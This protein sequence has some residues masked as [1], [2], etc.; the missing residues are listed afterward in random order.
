MRRNIGNELIVALFAAVSLIFAAVFAVLLST[1][2]S[3]RPTPTSLPTAQEIDMPVLAVASRTPERTDLPP[4]DTE[5]LPTVRTAV[6]TLTSAIILAATES[7]ALTDV[8]GISPTSV[9]TVAQATSGVIASATGQVPVVLT[10]TAS[11]SG[12]T[13]VLA[14]PEVEATERFPDFDPTTLVPTEVPAESGTAL[15]QARDA[16]APVPHPGTLPASPG[17]A[18]VVTAVSTSLAEDLTASPT[19]RDGLTEVVTATPTS[20]ATTEVTETIPADKEST[21]TTASA[22]PASTSA[23]MDGTAEVATEAKETS[24]LAPVA[25][26]IAEVSVTASATSSERVSEANTEAP[27]AISTVAV[28]TE[29]I[30]AELEKNTVTARAELRSTAKPAAQTEEAAV[31]S[32]KATPVDGILVDR[33][34]RTIRRLDSIELMPMR[35]PVVAPAATTA[36]A[37]VSLTP[38]ATATDLGVETETIEAPLT[39]TARMG[40]TRAD[41]PT[42]QP[43][44]PVFPPQ[45]TE[46]DVDASPAVET[47]V[48]GTLAATPSLSATGA[49]GRAAM[50]SPT[51]A[52]FKETAATKLPAVEEKDRRTPSATM[53]TT[54][55]GIRDKPTHSA[56][57]TPSST[58]V[59]SDALTAT[60]TKIVIVAQPVENQTDT[61]RATAEPATEESDPL[62]ATSTFE[63][64][65]ATQ[66]TT[67]ATQELDVTERVVRAT[68]TA[69]PVDQAAARPTATPVIE[70]ED[71]PTDSDSP[72]PA[73]TS[74]VSGALTTTAA[75]EP[76]LT[77]LAVARTHAARA[78]VEPT[79]EALVR[80]TSTV[81]VERS[82]T[83]PQ[84]SETAAVSE[85]STFEPSVSPQATTS[86]TQELD[87]TEGVVRATPTASPVDQAA[88][89]PTATPVIEPEDKPTDSDSPAPA[90]TSVVS[91]A[92][93]TTATQEPIMTQPATEESV[94][95][96][97]TIPGE[98]ATASPTPSETSAVS[99][100][101]TF[102]PSVSPQGMTSAT[103]KSDVLELEVTAIPTVSPVDQVR[104]RPLSTRRH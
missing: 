71:K 56:T 18:T 91:G 3:T 43:T 2:T 11:A 52:A 86:A 67:S 48:A 4:I 84:P 61:P 36:V 12:T 28:A 44:K 69:S 26:R 45:A 103:Q 73:T 99:E 72:A 29:K 19:A 21:P 51:V 13:E 40:A 65:V 75:Q 20:V 49:K 96:T 41:S 82:T 23:P 101:S 102:E 37:T 14:S 34:T 16:T 58:S 59:V 46:M 63:T 9:V 54:I 77:E 7:S 83:T 33:V 32:V 76:A 17:M 78:I 97:S 57:P 42:P 80:L 10:A 93:T 8:T 35:G 89:R 88:A 95:L 50:S 47:L 1:S 79:T 60:A 70:P 22:M 98:R 85:T 24:T 30:A 6:P 90:T 39:V 87:V 94:R 55:A 64:T 68:P 5:R 53:T 38:T 25:T 15:A 100:T 31:P 104:S 74:V 62:F 27:T 66:A 81:S 92:L